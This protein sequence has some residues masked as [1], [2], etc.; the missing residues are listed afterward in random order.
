MISRR[1]SCLVASLYILVG[2]ASGQTPTPPSSSD[3]GLLFYVSGDHG[4]TADVAAPGTARPTYDQEISVIPDGAQ[5]AALACGD[6][7]RLAWRAPGNIYAQRGSLSFFWRSRYAVGPTPFPVFRVGYGDHS[8]WD[9]VWL[10]IDYNGHGFDAFVTDASLAR[11]RVSVNLPTFPGPKE[12]THLVLA[13]DE[14]RGIRFYINGKLA[15]EVRTTAVYNA[16]LDQFGPHSR[17]ISPYNVQSDY[18]FVRGGDIDEIR[19]YDRM[20]PDDAVSALARLQQ[21][22]V[23]ALPARSIADAAV[24]DEWWLR[25]GWNRPSDPPPYYAGPELAIRK[26]EIHDAYDLKR[27]WWKATDGIRETTWPGVYNRS[28]LPG[29]NDYFQ[30]PDWD[31]YVESGKAVTFALPDE[32]WNHVEIAGAAWGRMELLR[33]T[34]D[35]ENASNAPAE[36]VLFERPKGQEKTVHHLP[37]SLTGRQIRFTNVEQEEPIGEL[38]VYNV[39]AGRAPAGTRHLSY[40]LAAPEDNSPA[41]LAPLQSYIKGRFATDERATLVGRP[42]TSDAPAA[43]TAAA[44]SAGGLPLVHLLIP[45]TWDKFSD[46]LDGVEIDMPALAVAP[47]H[48]TI[49]PVNIQIRDPLWPMRNALDFTFAVKP[50]EAKKLWF[51]LRDRLLPAGKALWIT[52]A[53][54]GA[55]LDANALAG[56][57]VTL[58][59]K[60]REAARPEHELD[61]FTQARDSY[62][63][64]VEEHPHSPLLN[65]W[66]RFETDLNDLLRVNPQH[67]LG[68]KYA[69]AGLGAPRPAIA[70]PAPPAGVPLWAARQTELL[71]RVQRFVFWYIDHRQVPFG[72]FGGGISDDVDLLNTWPGVALMGSDPAKIKASLHA[73]LEAA[74]KN[75]MFTNGLPTIQADE[76]HSYEEGINCLAQNLVLDYG[77]PR[78]LERAMVTA[79]GVESLTGINSAGHRHIRTSYYNGRKMAEDAPWGVAKPYSYLVLQPGQLL[80]DFNGSPRPQKYMLELADGLLAHRTTEADGSHGLPQGIEFATDNNVVATRGY[81]P[82]HVFWGAW[83]WTGKPEYLQPIFD[84]GTTGLTSVNANTLDI[85]NL[86][87]TWGARLS[88]NERGRG[89]EGGRA[90]TR[91]LA[92][93]HVAWQLTGDKSLLE[94]LY[95]SQ[96]QEC[97]L[98]EYINTTGSLWIDRVAVP[99]SELQRARLGGVSIVRNALYPGHTVSWDFAAPASGTSVAVLVPNA[100]PT[101][102]KVIAYNLE[103]TPVHATMTGWNIDPGIWEI[104]QGIDTRNAD[105]ADSTPTAREA[106]FERSGSLEFELPPRATT[107]L[108]LKLKTPGT[109]YWQRSDLGITADDVTV[110]GRDIHVLVHSVGAVAAPAARVVAKTAD[111]KIVASA[112]TPRLEAPVDLV[113]K[114]AELTLPLPKGVSLKGGS[115]EIQPADGVEEI[116][117]LNNRVR[118]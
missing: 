25:Y 77:N 17:I 48:G 115:I 42:E 97:D 38:V 104:T 108:T 16:A 51:D 83:K 41:D 69:I 10:R 93:N 70:L 26:V 22:E 52:V 60:T 15:G 7:E 35:L 100:T 55:G 19:I 76:L 73:L 45:D 80:V 40:R 107:I 20:L 43:A 9:M 103:T 34:K 98:L 64:L 116:T 50:H 110:R 54:A 30:L 84:A 96:I 5:G 91:T 68:L 90:A 31:C 12:W 66:V 59:F 47:T 49:Y 37:A 24:R 118:L 114:T 71:D 4:T 67:E 82:W 11:T 18:N 2:A 33:P 94:T 8:S 72:D 111:G 63:M 92:R 27:W 95:A 6:R 21:P 86:R 13:W 56:A 61:R 58:V 99:Y 79:K 1:L 117:A 28:R 88:G 3:P 78:Q 109:P 39:G 106:R 89:G 65:L 101:A 87:T 53:G 105:V 102:F 81:F 75:G 29:R 32:P 46:G 44:P 85:L 113:P 14:N 23:T 112:N 36:R 62:A 74:F 57:R